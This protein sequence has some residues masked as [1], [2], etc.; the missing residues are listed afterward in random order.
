MKAQVMRE[1]RSR[2]W[3]EE[4]GGKE[5]EGREL[6]DLRGKLNVDGD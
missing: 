4:A 3:G 2:V 6:V 5:G 1:V